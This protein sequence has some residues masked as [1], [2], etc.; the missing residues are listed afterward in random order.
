MRTYEEQIRE[1]QLLRDPLNYNYWRTLIDAEKTTANL[2][3]HEGLILAK[4]YSS[5]GRMLEAAKAYE[6]AFCHWREVLNDYPLLRR[7][8]ITADEL[9]EYVKEY[10]KIIARDL[11]EDFPLSDVVL[12]MEQN[13][14]AEI[15]P[16]PPSVVK[17]HPLKKLLLRKSPPKTRLQRRACQTNDRNQRI[18]THHNST[19]R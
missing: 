10:K 12:I 18:A 9:Y 14:S 15:A 8:S 4:Y 2:K 11:P 16:F 13:V 3:A 5:R 19:N 17:N 7:D 1:I 6:A